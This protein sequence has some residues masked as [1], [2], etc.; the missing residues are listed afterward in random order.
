MDSYIVELFYHI[1]LKLF[2]EELIQS[3]KNL[4]CCFVFTV[5]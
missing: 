4:L 3:Q 1:A 2:E 5:F